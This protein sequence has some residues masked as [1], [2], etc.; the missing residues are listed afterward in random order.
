[1][2][3]KAE[4]Q[5][6]NAEFRAKEDESYIVEGY[7]TTWEKYPLYEFEDRTVYEQ[8]SKED[9]AYLVKTLRLLHYHIAKKEE[10]PKDI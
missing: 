9:C 3:L 10:K 5:Y 7:A 4:R 1:M 2:P 6:R 8:F